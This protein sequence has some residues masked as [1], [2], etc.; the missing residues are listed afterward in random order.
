MTAQ[1]NTESIRYVSAGGVGNRRRTIHWIWDGPENEGMN[2]R[3][4]YYRMSF[5]RDDTSVNAGGY[6]VEYASNN[7]KNRVQRHRFIP[8]A[9][10]SVGDITQTISIRV[11]GHERLCLCIGSLITEVQHARNRAAN[12]GSH[13]FSRYIGPVATRFKRGTMNAL[14]DLPQLARTCSRSL[15]RGYSYGQKEVFSQTKL[16]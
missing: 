7:V 3:A 11:S 15:R 13:E 16:L 1:D 5:A 8:K 4:G 6:A 2:I 10:C 14:R 12:K 9:N